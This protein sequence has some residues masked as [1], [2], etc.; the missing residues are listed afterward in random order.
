[1]AAPSW[2]SPIVLRA[3]E[4]ALANVR[5]FAPVLRSSLESLR[6]PIRKLDET[7]AAVIPFLRQ[8][9]KHLGANLDGLAPYLETAASLS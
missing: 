7:N 1:M 5:A 4:S 6:P 3:S 8:S 2:I 9:P